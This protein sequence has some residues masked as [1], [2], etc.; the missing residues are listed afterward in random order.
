MRN[1]VDSLALAFRLL[2]AVVLTILGSVF[3]GIWIDQRAGTAPWGVLAL[4]ILGIVLST[5]LA[6][7]LAN[8]RY[9]KD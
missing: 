5:L 4:T 8:V 3:L 7:R 9:R 2:T 1:L 6:Y